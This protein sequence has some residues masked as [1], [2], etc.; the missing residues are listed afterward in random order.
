MLSLIV[1]AW[2]AYLIHGTH[3]GTHTI[4]LSGP[5]TVGI[6][7]VYVSQAWKPGVWHTYVYYS[8]AKTAIIILC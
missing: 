1:K 5:S 4:E 2:F 6:Q 7:P 3:P 8:I